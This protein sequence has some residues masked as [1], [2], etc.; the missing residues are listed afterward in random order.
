MTNGDGKNRD[1]TTAEKMGYP[2]EARLL[3]INADDFGMCH[4]E[5]EATILGLTQ[6]VFTS[7]TILTPCPWFEEA[8]EF[9]RN[10]PNADLGVHLTL[11][12]EWERYKW[13]PVLGRTD[14]P[15]LTDERGYLWADV[16]SVFAHDRL[17]EVEIELQAQIEKAIAAG[18]EVT[19]LDC[20]MGPLHVRASYH[21]IYLKLALDFRLPIRLNPRH[22]MRQFGMGDILSA[23]DGN[24]IFYPDNFL[25]HGRRNIDETEAYWTDVIRN[26]EPGISEIY[27]HPAMARE[28]LKACARDWQQRQ[29]DF[30]Y[31]TSEKTRQLI[32]DE[33]I[34]LIGY[35]QLRD[36][37]TDA[38][39]QASSSSSDS[40]SLKGRG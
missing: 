17:E 23:L 26:L 11:N 2:A 14:V 29:R 12:S 10:T 18:I 31:F 37:M 33:G 1:I 13:G 28:E 22:T 8:A 27:C 34:Q 38:S 7:S 21:R 3:I 25:H 4:D 30:E 6:G 32:K 40:P 5:N 16:P 20:H 15:S 9:G 36:A 35:R 19:H 24:S 39:K